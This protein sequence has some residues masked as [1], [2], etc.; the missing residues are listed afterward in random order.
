MKEKKY[1]IAPENPAKHL[2]WYTKTEGIAPKKNRR[3][4]FLKVS[5]ILLGVL[6]L[7]LAGI[8]GAFLYLRIKGE[9]SLKT[10]VKEINEGSEELPEGI[11][12]TYQGKQ[13]RY[14][15]DIISFLCLGIDKE[16]EIEE[17]RETGSEGL[18]DAIL[19]VSINVESN[20]L[21]ILAIPREAVIPVKVLD[22]GGN[23]I[24]T[25]NKQITLQF[26]YGRSAEESCELMTEAVS[27]L[28]Y[29]L[30]IQRYCAV[31]FQ[32]IPVLNDAVGGVRLTSLE[33]VEWWDGIFYE[34][35]ELDLRGKSALD[36]V[37]QRNEEVAESSMGRL[38]RQKQYVV[39]YMEQA[40]AAVKEDLT[41][42]IQLYQSLTK[43][44]RTNV[45]VEDITYL[46]PEV[47]G[48]NL[49]LD[50]ISMVPGVTV[51]AGSQEEYHVDEEALKELVI[52]T[53]YEEV[54][55]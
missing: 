17:K 49:T 32:A 50:N 27:N 44:M 7:V 28:L 5:L 6:F 45:T 36:Y 42:P 53:F 35:E 19:L 55:E 31:N 25:E 3:R 52:Q 15:S 22:T 51:P 14:N 48:M 18:A 40:K 9:R 43:H 20:E 34:G 26:A 12:T 4:T 37:R 29:K 39:C 46:V 30:P 1:K 33:T 41:L 24:R 54:P 16:L 21:K 13:Y 8:A 23:F 38:E 2:N 10:E 11:Y 47:L